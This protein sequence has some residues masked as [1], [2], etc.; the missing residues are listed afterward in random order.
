MNALALEL[1][2]LDTAVVNPSGLDEPGQLTSAYDLALIARA[3]LERDDF[4][5][6]ATTPTA[7]LPTRTARPTRSRT[8]TGCSART[9]A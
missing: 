2:A 9:T 6:Y 5:A 8:A 3:A 7:D 1:Q 4:R